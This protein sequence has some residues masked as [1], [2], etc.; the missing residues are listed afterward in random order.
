MIFVHTT[1]GDMN[2]ATFSLIQLY[3]AIKR[4]N[5]NS[6]RYEFSDI[7]SD[8]VVR[9]RKTVKSAKN[10]SCDTCAQNSRRYESSH[11][12]A[13]TVVISRKTVKSANNTICDTC[14]QNSRKYE[15][16]DI[17]VRLVRSPKTLVVHKTRGDMSFFKFFVHTIVISRKT[18]KS[19]KN[20]ICDICAHNSWRYEFCDIFSHTVVF[21]HKT[22]KSELA[23]I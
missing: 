18:V 1:R 3:L 20:T 22:V 23:E 7:F 8:T 21:S 19:A 12:F 9:S 4:S 5:Q 17:F 6:R 2:F 11:I 13:H 15:F 10:T 16:S 14:T